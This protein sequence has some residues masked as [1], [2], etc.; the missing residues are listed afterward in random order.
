MPETIQS[1]RETPAL[2]ARAEAQ[3]TVP[4]WD[5]PLR[6]W[7]WALAF[8]VLLAWF[9]PTTH[10]T[11]HRIAG[12]TI[13]GLLIFRFAWGFL[14]SRYSRFKRMVPRL[15]AAPS[16]LWGLRHGKTG[17]Y[18]GLNPAGAAMLVALL[19]ALTVSAVT[20]A[21]SVTT[22]FFGVWWIEDT[23]A[24]ASDAVIVLVIVHVL[25]TILMS[26]LQR[27]NLPRA[28]FTGR[29]RRHVGGK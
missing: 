27:E 8:F 12:Y 15:R 3:T 7:H 5:R 10:D 23:H 16:Y 1:L 21:M 19:V 9:T 22:T 6:A 17:R 2:P 4:V 25:G 13:I 24:Y 14:G 29:K 28:M 11:T 18:L 20:G 26:I